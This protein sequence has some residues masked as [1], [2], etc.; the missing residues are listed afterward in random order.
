MSIWHYLRDHALFICCCIAA[1]WGCWAYLSGLDVATDAVTFVVIVIAASGAAPLVVDYL[2]RADWYRRTQKQLAEMDKPYLFYT[3]ME[4]PGFADG[5]ICYNW[6]SET[7][8]AMNE[9]VA[10]SERTMADYREYLERWVHEIKMPIATALLTAEN[11]PSPEMRSIQ[12][13]LKRIE[14]YVMQV[15][16]YAR[17]ASL[18]DDYIITACTLSSLVDAALRRNARQLIRSGFTIEKKELDASV[19]TD[20]KWL[21]FVLDQLIQNAVKYRRE[22]AASLRF[23]QEVSEDACDLLIE[24]SGVGVPDTDL[25]RLFQKGFTGENGRKF[26]KATGMGLYISQNL[27]RKMNHSICAE[28]GADGGLLIRIRFPKGSMHGII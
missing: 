4:E 3:V 2:R 8:H 5:Q 25:P 22:D 20:G 12:E 10:E 9:R 19:R 23:A 18:K 11:H 27:L 15:L 16:Y 6:M 24:D 17:S 14:S 28:H 7:S 1:A 26:S 13:D 21:G